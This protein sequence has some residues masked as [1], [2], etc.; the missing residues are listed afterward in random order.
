VPKEG[1]KVT[2][3]EIIAYCRERIAGYKIPRIVEL[4]TEIPRTPTGKIQ[5]HTL[6]ESFPGPAPE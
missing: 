4:T 3:E 1:E 6:R 5:K 2:A